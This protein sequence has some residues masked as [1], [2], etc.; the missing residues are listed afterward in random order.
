MHVYMLGKVRGDDHSSRILENIMRNVTDW[1]RGK[2]QTW[3][4]E[5]L[6]ELYLFYR[7]KSSITYR[8]YLTE[9]VKC[10]NWIKLGKYVRQGIRIGLSLNKIIYVTNM[11]LRSTTWKITQKENL[12]QQ[13]PSFQS[14]GAYVNSAHVQHRL[15]GA[16]ATDC[17]WKESGKKT[18]VSFAASTSRRFS[19]SSEASHPFLP[20]QPPTVA[21]S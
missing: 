9:Y 11:Q 6:A 8:S 14:A 16:T 19:S 1:S 18:P 20:V 2:W 7:T 12:M 4:S 10:Y 17:T 13:V 5:T 15:Q 21:A 3:L